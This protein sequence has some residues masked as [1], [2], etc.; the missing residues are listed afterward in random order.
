[1]IAELAPY[2]PYIIGG[3][4]LV[5]VVGLVAVGVATRSEADPLQDRLAEFVDS[6]PEELASLEQLEMSVPFTQRILLPIMQQIAKIVQGFTPQEAL[7]KTQLQLDLAGNPSGLTPPVFWTF[8]IVV[9][10]ALT[11]LLGFVFNLSSSIS[12]VRALLYTVGGALLGFFLPP[13]WL[14]SK[15]NT[16]QDEILKSLPDALDLMTVCVEAGLGFDAA[17]TKVAEKWDN[18]LAIAFARVITEIQLGKLRR[19]ALRDM[20][21]RMGVTD[22]STFVASIIQAD[23]LGVSISK[24]LHIQSEQMRI[25]RRQRAEEKAQQAPIKMLFPLAFLIFPTIFMVLLGPSALM[26][27]ENPPF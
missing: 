15:I 17:M 5:I 8:R 12:G 9:M 11:V 4:A 21:D 13:L 1:M 27:F 24:I 23:Q 14:R 10:V 22:V 3:I 7:E 2:L 16:R 19:E 6:R 25:R 26:I 18:Q 20:A